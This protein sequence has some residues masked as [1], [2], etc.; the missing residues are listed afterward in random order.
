MVLS[1][2]GEGPKA[3]GEDEEA[4]GRRR[5]VRKHSSKGGYLDVFLVKLPAGGEW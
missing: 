3:R 1:S 2:E 5:G 4:T